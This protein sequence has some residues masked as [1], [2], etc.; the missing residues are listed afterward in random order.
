MRFAIERMRTL[1]LVAG[2]LLLVALVAFLVVDKWKSSFNRRDLPQ[3]LGLDIKQEANGYT[4]AHAFGAHSQYKIHASKLVQLKDN[5]A[6]LH[7]VQIEL[8][9][10]DGSRIGSVE[11]AEFE[12]DLKSEVA[13]A[14]GPVEIWLLHPEIAPVIAPKAGAGDAGGVKAKVNPLASVAQAASKGQVHVK[15]SGL[16]FDRKS[17]VATTAERVD[18]SMA[19]GAGTAMGATYDSDK[20]LLVLSRAVELTTE[21]NGDHVR[22]HARHAEFERGSLVCRFQSATADFK[23][24]Q[25]LAG[26]AKVLFRDDGSAVRLD[27]LSGFSLTTATGTRLAAPQGTMIFDERNQPRSGR[28]E[29]GVTLDSETESVGRRHRVHGTAPTAVLEFTARG[30]L[31][32]AHLERGVAVDS[33]DRD[34][35]ATASG[36]DS[37]QLNRSWRS[38]VADIEFRDYG[39]GKVEPASIHGSG[40]VVV[41]GDDR[42]GQG[43]V[44]PSRLSADELTGEFDTGQALRLIRG[45]GHVSIYEKTASGAQQSTTGDRLEAHFKTS[46][47]SART[48]GREGVIQSSTIE[49]HVTLEQIPVQNGPAKPG[50]A[51]LTPLKAVAGRAAYEES[52]RW[53]HLTLSPRIEDGGLQLTADR[54]DISR[55][56]G[57][58]FAHGNVKA[59]WMGAG[60]GN[61]GSG[62]SSAGRQGQGNIALGGQG[63]AHAIASEAQLHDNPGGA[64]VTFR[65]QARLWQQANSIAAPEIVLDR[66]H[67]ALTASSKDAAEP[68]RAVFVSAGGLATGKDSGGKQT[69]ASVIRVR[70]GDL[71]YSD[72]DRVALMRGGALDRVVAETGTAICISNEVELT[73]HA[74]G[75][76]ADAGN[77]AAEVDRMVARGH[78]VLTSE[79]RRGTGE[80]LLFT[81]QTW[82]YVLTGSPAAPPM[83]ID[84]ARGSVTGE[85]LIFNGRDD[86][87]RIEGGGRKT[88]TETTA[89]R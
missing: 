85:A 79:G 25:A 27:A 82:E 41:T 48:P 33:E 64:T 49:G 58:G 13:K 70:G 20:G 6:V 38:P 74:A 73:L 61:P 36:A 63:P 60:S 87:V 28:L 51:P 4:F 47:S 35:S 66:E 81:G 46:G 31:R 19:Q 80:Q 12:D 8:F 68:V 21:R 2:V 86:S 44:S 57:D 56:S 45:V 32:R 11:G 78:V 59:S 75:S 15:T 10:V 29:G 40:G 16:T 34:E 9:G 62:I 65:G 43:A 30:R 84:P 72:A 76:H 3:R 69:A 53:L 42:R 22:I 14:T 39:D 55:L 1:V 23:D 17:G 88:A 7:D 71:R 24:A 18:F 37:L 83:L 89:P 54:L 26:E 5:R 67:H 52:G 77:G 50:A